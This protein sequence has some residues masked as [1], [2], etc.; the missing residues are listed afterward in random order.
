LSCISNKTTIIE[1]FAEYFFKDLDVIQ[2]TVRPSRIEAIGLSKDNVFYDALNQVL[3]EAFGEIPMDVI[4][5]TIKYYGEATRSPG[6]DDGTL[7]SGQSLSSLPMLNGFTSGGTIG[8]FGVIG[9]TM[10]A[11]TAAH[12]VSS[13]ENT[14]RFFD[15]KTDAAFIKLPKQEDLEIVN[16]LYFDDDDLTKFS[17]NGTIENFPYFNLDTLETGSTVYKFGST[18]LLTRGSFLGIHSV[19]YLGY[20]EEKNE[21][22]LTKF[23]EAIC[24]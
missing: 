14:V 7:L 17:I 12:C 24:I 5:G 3:A 18:T 16:S 6:R 23:D 8:G 9:E 13:E 21:K 20:D 19:S 4:K 15:G 10:L 22:V 1:P 2:F 11:V